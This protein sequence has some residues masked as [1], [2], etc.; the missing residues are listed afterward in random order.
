LNP[1]TRG[2]KDIT[3]NFR[4]LKII[5]KDGKLKLRAK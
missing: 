3:K 1:N 2:E 4:K 5:M